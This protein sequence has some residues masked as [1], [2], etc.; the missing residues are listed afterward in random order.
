MNQRIHTAAA[1]AIAALAC[2]TAT[3]LAA[4]NSTESALGVPGSPPGAPF[5]EAA[6][7]VP[8]ETPE[9]TWNWHLQNTDI[10]Q[11]DPGFPA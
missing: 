4:T 8:D 6:A 3:I 9:R 5:P 2:G 7:K 11:G 10:V 1:G